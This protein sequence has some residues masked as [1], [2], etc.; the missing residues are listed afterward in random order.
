[1][2][3]QKAIDTLFYIQVLEDERTHK[4]RIRVASDSF[5]VKD[6]LRMIEM[7]KEKA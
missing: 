1:M 5:L 3:E 4:F 6:Q 7:D 2:A